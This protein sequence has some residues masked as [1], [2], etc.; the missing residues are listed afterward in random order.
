[1]TAD[2][3]QKL[4]E[5][6]ANA[7]DTIELMRLQIDALEQENTTLKGEQDKWRR[8][9]KALLSRF[10]AIESPKHAPANE[11]AEEEFMTV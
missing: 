5:K 11:V 8:D 6:I 9:L 10:D 3:L 2:L 1:M 7:L 4:E